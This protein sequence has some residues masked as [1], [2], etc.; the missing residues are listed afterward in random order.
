MLTVPKLGLYLIWFPRLWCTYL[1]SQ[2][3]EIKI[4]ARPFPLIKIELNSKTSIE[5]PR[6]KL[7]INTLLCTFYILSKRSLC[8]P[9]VGLHEK[10]VH[11]LFCFRALY[12]FFSSLFRQDYSCCLTHKLF[13]AHQDITS[14]YPVVRHKWKNRFFT[15][16]SWYFVN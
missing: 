1:L 13:T 2:L 3:K 7:I 14:T 16:K 5:C 15:V 12:V 11:D 10:T 9:G 4:H 6:A 8:Q